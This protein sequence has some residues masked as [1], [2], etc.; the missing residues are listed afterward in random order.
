MPEG[1]DAASQKVLTYLLWLL[2]GTP[3]AFET[4][5]KDGEAKKKQVAETE[6]KKTVKYCIAKRLTFFFSLLCCLCAG[7]LVYFF[8]FVFGFCICETKKKTKLTQRGQTTFTSYDSYFVVPSCCSLEDIEHTAMGHELPSLYFIFLPFL[9]NLRFLLV[10]RHGTAR[11]PRTRLL[12]HSTAIG[13]I[14]RACVTRGRKTTIASPIHPGP[15]GGEVSYVAVQTATLT[16][17]WHRTAPLNLYPAPSQTRWR[18]GG[19]IRQPSRTDFLYP[20]SPV[21]PFMF[22]NSCTTRQTA[23]TNDIHSLFLPTAAQD[24]AAYAALCPLVYLLHRSDEPAATT[25]TSAGP[26]SA[27]TSELVDDDSVAAASVSSHNPRG[28]VLFSA[29]HPQLD[30]L[31]AVLRTQEV[32]F[33]SMRE[34]GGPKELRR[35]KPMPAISPAQRREKTKRKGGGVVQREVT[36]FC[37]VPL[38][39]A[40]RVRSSSSSAAA[41]PGPSSLLRGVV[42]TSDGRVSAFTEYGYAFSFTAHHSPIAAAHAIYNPV[43][44]AAAAAEEE[45]GRPSSR[46]RSPPRRAVNQVHVT[47]D[48]THASHR[49]ADVYSTSTRAA[50]AAAGPF[51]ALGFVT[52]GRDGSVCVWRKAEGLVFRPRRLMGERPLFSRCSAFSLYSPPLVPHSAT[53]FLAPSPVLLHATTEYFSV[54]P[55]IPT[56]SDRRRVYPD[57]YPIPPSGYDRWHYDLPALVTND[58]GTAA[59]CSNGV[60][61]LVARDYNIYRVNAV[62]DA[63]P[64]PIMVTLHPITAI[65]MGEHLA[66]LAAL[67]YGVVLIIRPDESSAV[68]LCEYTS[69]KGRPLRHVA[70]HECA[71]TMILV[72]NLGSVELV[73]LP[74]AYMETAA[75]QA[76]LEPPGLHSV[77]YLLPSVWMLQARA[78]LDD[79]VEAERS[80]REARLDEQDVMHSLVLADTLPSGC[81]SPR[82]AVPAAV[83]AV[84]ARLRGR[85][86]RMLHANTSSSSVMMASLRGGQQTAASLQR[87]QEALM[88][89]RLATQQPESAVVAGSSRLPGEEEDSNAP[90]HQWVAGEP[91]LER[92]SNTHR[93]RSASR[94]GKDGSPLNRAEEVEVE[95]VEVEA[96]Q[97]IPKKMTMKQTNA[98]NNNNNNKYVV[99]SGSW[100]L[101]AHRPGPIVFVLSLGVGAVLRRISLTSDPDPSKLPLTFFFF[102]FSLTRFRLCATVLLVDYYA[103]TPCLLGERAKG[104][105]KFRTKLS[106]TETA[107]VPSRGILSPVLGVPSRAYLC[108]FGGPLCHTSEMFRM[109]AAAALLASQIPRSAWDPAHHNENW[110]DSYGTDIAERRQWPSKRWSVG[111]V[112]RTP[113]DWLKYSTRNLA[114]AYNGAL[115]ACDAFPEMLELYKEMKQRGVKVDVDTLNALLTRGARFEGL[116]V[117]DLFLLFDEMVGLGVRPDIAALETLHTVLDHSAGMPVEWREVRRRQLVEWYNRV[118]VEVLER[119]K[120]SDTHQMQQPV[121]ALMRQQMQRLRGNLQQLQASISPHVY[122]Q[123]FHCLQSSSVLLH[124]LHNF[125]W[126]FVQPSHHATHITALGMSIPAVWTVMRRPALPGTTLSATAVYPKHTATEGFRVT[127]FEDSDVCSVFLA[128]LERIVDA[129]FQLDPPNV[130][131]RRL[132]LSLLTILEAT[133]VLVTSDLLAQLMDVVKYGEEDAVRDTYAQRVLRHAVKG[134]RTVPVDPHKETW[135]ALQP[136]DGRIIGRYLASRHPWSLHRIHFEAG[137]AQ[138]RTYAPAI[139]SGAPSLSHEDANSQAEEG[140]AR[141]SEAGDASPPPVLA[142]RP[143]QLPSLHVEQNRTPEAFAARW[144]D[145]KALIETTGV[146]AAPTMAMGS[147]ASGG[148]DADKMEAAMEVFTGQMVL[149]RT[150]ATGHRYETLSEALATQAGGAEL[151]Q[152]QQ[153]LGASGVVTGPV[154]ALDFGVWQLLLQ[155][156]KEVHLEMEQFM[157][158]TGGAAEPEF[159]C[160][161]SMLVA[162]RCVLDYCTAARGRLGS[163]ATA[164]HSSEAVERLFEEAAALRSRLVEESRTRFG[165]RL[166]VLWLQE[167]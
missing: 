98:Y 96:G 64:T 54:W 14:E 16:G 153:Q 149:L 4:R 28:S 126:E 62:S 13:F 8:L 69:Y 45:E 141:G 134:L 115:R 118:A 120:P 139:S 46:S 101:E 107:S 166:R 83:R 130:S 55:A 154:A 117:D 37:L 138:F 125:L 167:V 74:R 20:I 87:C 59:V 159:E 157:A 160:W 47:L 61:A 15:L 93:A 103:V 90:P 112:P 12:L 99:Q 143:G 29:L 52:V 5:N 38:D 17:L 79:A 50:A 97:R 95:V 31:V 67:A 68:L 164:T 89:A 148:A 22:Q 25:C 18:S 123:Y 111:L 34:T 23:G 132:F 56:A 35:F 116:Q 7:V 145:V 40:V 42:G 80:R 135:Q 24:R 140:G 110:T 6:A 57:T 63:K 1:L 114:Y 27:C 9:F 84:F 73:V 32:I 108:H 88:L 133:G 48:P 151:Q 122:R 77:V 158:S 92:H 33:F 41:L 72:D 51:A 127:D 85:R 81:P 155:Y 124:E 156:L 165:G 76:Q 19:A 60:Y 86:H 58:G 162:L 161:E 119:L 131:G 30:G 49:N 66:V 36:A 3:T 53:G 113:K 91:P 128:A 144:A 39:V 94:D 10:S 104:E 105:E 65:D 71:A 106:D 102:F 43:G 11:H 137:G 2:L 142:Q 100:R 26:S 152:Q 78:A 21:L 75:R 147:T 109:G 44:A 136:V 129:D 146:L 70:L 82:R 163:D 121:D 150:A